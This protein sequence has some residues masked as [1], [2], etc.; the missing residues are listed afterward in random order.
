M[1]DVRNPAQRLHRLAGRS[2]NDAI[3]VDVLV[4]RLQTE[5]Y[6]CIRAYKGYLAIVYLIV[7]DH[8]L[9]SG[10][11]DDTDTGFARDVF[12]LVIMTK[13]MTQMVT[14]YG[15]LLAIDATHNTNALRF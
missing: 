13:F 15:G 14:R 1:E 9:A 5:D 3:A 11:D 12:F 6:N 8:E 7:T 10:V 4:Q 2:S